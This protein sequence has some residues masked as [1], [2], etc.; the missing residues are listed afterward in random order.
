MHESIDFRVDDRQTRFP[1]RNIFRVAHFVQFAILGVLILA[2]IHA[3]LGY[4]VVSRGV[5]FVDLS[6]AQVSALGTTIAFCVAGLP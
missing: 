3:Y 1:D 5:I 6:L 2:G 4:H